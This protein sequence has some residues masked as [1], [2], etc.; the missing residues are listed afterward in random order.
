M[1]SQAIIRLTSSILALCGML[2]VATHSSAA[3]QVTLDAAD[4][5]FVKVESAAGT[6]DLK[7]AGLGVQK[8]ERPDVKNFAEMLVEEHIRTN[9]QLQN[10]AVEKGVDVSAVVDP[11][12]A[13]A[14][15]KLEKAAKADFDR[16]FL[17]GL[18]SSHKTCV[19]NFEAAARDSKDTDV[20]AWAARM[21]LTIK[22]HL[23][24]ARELAV[25]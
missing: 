22:E 12:H 4:I 14:F 23:A 7:F 21:L 9:R 18:I 11:K 19:S 2:M 15:Q 5:K 20:K 17:A 6:A 1:K 3:P 8:A 25:E 10:L 24:K 13:E 16:E